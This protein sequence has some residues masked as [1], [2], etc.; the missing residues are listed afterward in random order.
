MC[1]HAHDQK[2]LKGSRQLHH[3]SPIGYLPCHQFIKTRP[4]MCHMYE[5][6]SR[7]SS[8]VFEPAVYFLSC[9]LSMPSNRN[10]VPCFLPKPW[11]VPDGSFCFAGAASN[12]NPPHELVWHG[13]AAWHS[14]NRSSPGSSKKWQNKS[15]SQSIV[16]MPL[17]WQWQ[18]FAFLAQ[19]SQVSFR[20]L[21]KD[22]KHQDGGSE[23]H[24]C[25]HRRAPE[26]AG[27]PCWSGKG[28]SGSLASRL[29]RMA[30]TV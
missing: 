18:R 6:V 5:P 30:K 24:A 22:W 7:Q 20:A 12:M 27:S 26:G 11:T 17:M 9:L 2:L 15:S 10:D 4:W 8:F 14:I 16:Q 3:A 1:F 21:A 23:A 25:P 19:I 13:M 29:N 28:G